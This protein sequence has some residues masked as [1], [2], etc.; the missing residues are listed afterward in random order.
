[1]CSLG[2]N[3]YYPAGNVTDSQALLY[4]MD[5]GLFEYRWIITNWCLLPIAC[6]LGCFCSHKHMRDNNMYGGGYNQGGNYY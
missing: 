4:T 1:V 6:C 2:T 3:I 5:V